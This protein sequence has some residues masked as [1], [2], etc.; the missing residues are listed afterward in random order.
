[1]EFEW[2]ENKNNSN[3]EKHGVSF[4]EAKEVFSDDKRIT[5]EDARNDYG[6]VRYIMIGYIFKGM[7]SAVYTIRG[8]AY[9]IISA[10]PANRKER[11]K[12]N[13]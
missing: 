4:E 9:R 1:M 8:L 10:R 5:Y 13:K 7:I 12:Y 3:K 11:K 6:E 2:D